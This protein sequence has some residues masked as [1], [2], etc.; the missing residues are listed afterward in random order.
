MTAEVTHV[1]TGGAGF[2][3]VNLAQRLLDRADRVVLID[4]LSRGSR[5]FVGRLV[6]AD[7]V[8]FRE[9]DVADSAAL[10]A[11]LDFVPDE[12]VE[13]WHL[14]AN[15]DIPAGVNDPDVDLKDT[16][17]VTHALLAY[18]RKR[19]WK[20]LQFSSTSAV[21]GDH[22][23]TE[24]TEATFCQPI[25]NYG[26]MKLASEAAICAAAEFFLERACIF[27]FPNV[28]GV[29]ATHGVILDFL[30]KLKRT[31]DVLEVLGNGTQRKAYLH[32]SDLI[33]AMLWLYDKSEGRLSVYNIG[34][35]DDGV[36]VRD[37]AEMTRDRAS[38]KASL[39]FGT[40]DRGWI[41][42]VPR[43]RYNTDR[44]RG[45][46]W[47]P[48]LTSRQAVALAIDEIVEQEGITGGEQIPA[49][50]KP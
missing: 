31:P 4:N 42:D 37:I 44:L 6:P 43:F 29:P 8:E 33:D 21:Y 2:V 24:L 47:T 9:A 40:E 7:R 38:P 22:G 26:A 48:S 28:V 10:A 39:R 34:P 27:R 30:H 1:V 35:P 36:T 16:F 3:A 32:V 17:L 12:R 41:G 5:E 46:G 18:M 25:S 49:C 15:S 50:A 13:V 20:R 23:T 45:F 14:C 11:A 19:G